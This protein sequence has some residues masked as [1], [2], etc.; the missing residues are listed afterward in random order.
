MLANSEEKL[1]KV[2]YNNS[3][4][5]LEEGEELYSNNKLKEALKVLSLV[6]SSNIECKSD[7]FELFML[8]IIFFSSDII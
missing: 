2:F 5:K 3:K 7:W 1:S 6:K 8:P 4:L